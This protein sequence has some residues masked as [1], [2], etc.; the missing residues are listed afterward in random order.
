MKKK[1]EGT[2][3]R[4]RLNK[5]KK[6]FTSTKMTIEARH[7]HFEETVL[8]HMKGIAGRKNDLETEKRRKDELEYMKKCKKADAALCQNEGNK[9]VK[10]WKNYNDIK[11]YLQPLKLEGVDKKWPTSREEIND[12]F[13]EWKNRKRCHLVLEECV[14]NK[15]DA[16]TKQEK[17]KQKGTTKGKKTKQKNGSK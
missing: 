11:A 8:D 17:T 14:W 4:E 3:V 1:E 7:Y 13:D 16:W 2:T 5:F 15:F 9:N 10:D 12:L 6:R